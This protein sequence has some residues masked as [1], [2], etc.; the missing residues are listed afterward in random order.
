MSRHNV[1]TDTSNHEEELTVP[2]KEA[3]SMTA[4]STV[5]SITA[6]ERENEEAKFGYKAPEK[7][8]RKYQSETSH[9]RLIAPVIT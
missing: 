5:S 2:V 3:D 6:E 4:A 8:R 9:A 1:D 7:N